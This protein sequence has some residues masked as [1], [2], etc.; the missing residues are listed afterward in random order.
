MSHFTVIGPVRDEYLI[1]ADADLHSADAAR[2]SRLEVLYRSRAVERAEALMPIM[3]AAFGV[4]DNWPNPSP[5]WQ[6]QVVEP[7]VTWEVV[8]TRGLFRRRP[9]V[10]GSEADSQMALAAIQRAYT[11]G[12]QVTL[13]SL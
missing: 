10:T 5:L 12:A 1:V 8:S 2:R 3:E 6:V 11:L 13:A 7:G 4:G 9:Y